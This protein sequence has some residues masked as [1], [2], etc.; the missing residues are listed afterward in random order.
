[1]EATDLGLFGPDSV[2]WRVLADPTM[3]VASMRA[4]YLQALHPR[5]VRIVHRHSVFRTEP[6]R[7]FIRTADYIGALTYG[8]TE[9]ARRAAARV[10]AVH[11]RVP[12]ASDPELLLWVHC[13]EIESFLDTVRRAG[14]RLSA[15]DADRYVEEQVAAAELI[16][17]AGA[18]SS[19]A[20][21][22]AYFDEIRPELAAT[23]EA[24]DIVRFLAVPPMPRAVALGTPARPAWAGLA[25]LAFAL[26]PRWARRLYRLPGLPTTDVAATIAV[27][28]LRT[29]LLAV[30]PALRDGPYVKQAKSR[31][32]ADATGP[33]ARAEASAGL[34]VSATQ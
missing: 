27:R 25:A 14:L 3:G 31:I 23:S 20:G 29:A 17:A 12:G 26:L 18:P 15:A 1:M 6:W 13:G 7:R 10:R 28:S 5:T 21:L 4:L 30:P 24:Y 9:Q 2:T 8:T 33:G 32:A 16:G 22:R 19:V 34:S 11:D